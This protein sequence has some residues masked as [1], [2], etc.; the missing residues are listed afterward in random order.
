MQTHPQHA[1]A[2]D[3]AL[4]TYAD[5][6]NSPI[7]EHRQRDRDSKEAFSDGDGDMSLTSSGRPRHRTLPPYLT[8]SPLLLLSAFS[9]L[10]LSLLFTC[11]H[12][13]LHGSDVHRNIAQAK[14]ELLSACARAE[15]RASSIASLPR[16]LA[17][18]VNRGTVQSVTAVVHGAAR[19]FTLSITAIEAVLIFIVDSYRSLFLW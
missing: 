6:V 2:A 15:D 5:H 17:D 1:A 4:P 18:G 3:T 8:L 7:L 16:Y 13:L 12:L 19:V 14:Q 9:P 10:I 11:I